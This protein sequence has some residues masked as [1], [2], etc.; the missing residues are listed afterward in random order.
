[1][2]SFWSA[3]ALLPLFRLMNWRPN[4][5]LGGTGSA[6]K[7]AAEPAYRRQVAALQNV[8]MPTI[9]VLLEV[10]YWSFVACSGRSLDRRGVRA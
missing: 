8:G 10:G 6:R 7:A 5:H 4:A 9:K 1:M 3:G 2:T